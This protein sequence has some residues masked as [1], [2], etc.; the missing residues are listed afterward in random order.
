MV[1]EESDVEA[2]A[3]VPDRDAVCGDPVALSATLSVAENVPLTGGVKLTLMA[4]LAAAASVVPQV[5][6]KV[7]AEEAV[8]PPTEIAMPVSGAVPG[9][10]SVMVCCPADVVTVVAAKVRVDGVRIAWGNA[11]LAAAEP[12]NVMVWEEPGVLLLLSVT[13]SVAV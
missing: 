8:P 3:P 13:V 1:L 7:K 9:F 11:V 2:A 5:V 10:E 12:V 4:Q 6:V